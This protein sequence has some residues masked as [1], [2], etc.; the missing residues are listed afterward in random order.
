MLTVGIENPF[1][2]SLVELFLNNEDLQTWVEGQMQTKFPDFAK[3]Q[4]DERMESEEYWNK[5][6]E[7]CRECLKEV[8][9][10]LTFDKS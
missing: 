3:L 5:Y 7:L 10:N 9:D 6:T 8:S 4:G 1:I 2:S